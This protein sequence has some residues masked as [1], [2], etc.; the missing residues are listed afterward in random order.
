MPLFDY[1]HLLLLQWL[2]SGGQSSN[3]YLNVVQVSTAVLLRHLW[4]LK[5][6]VF[7]HW[8]Q[9]CAVPLFVCQHLLLL[10]WLPSGGQNSNLY[11]QQQCYLDI[12]GSLRQLFFCIGVKYVLFYCLITNIYS[13]SH[14]V[15][16][17]LIFI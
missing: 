5:T 9:I 12:C 16:K 7:L 11:F 3:L 1:Q 17:V 8:C 13:Y 14:L 6:V 2:P 10:Q 4:Q 15:V